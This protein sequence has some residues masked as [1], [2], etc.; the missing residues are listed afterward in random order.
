MKVTCRVEKEINEIRLLSSRSNK[1]TNGCCYLLRIA[2]LGSGQGRTDQ[3]Q[4]H[5][6]LIIFSFI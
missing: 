4:P 5:S 1:D 2:R 3:E 6:L